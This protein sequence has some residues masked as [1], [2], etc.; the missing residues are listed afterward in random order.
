M[1]ENTA[2]FISPDHFFPNNKSLKNV[3]DK[4]DQ[5]NRSLYLISNKKIISSGIKTQIELPKIILNTAEI[6]HNHKFF[7]EYNKID[8]L[9]KFIY[10]N[11][12]NFAALIIQSYLFPNTAETKLIIDKKI[13]KF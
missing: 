8:N 10:K 2:V 5:N 12:S 13:S 3:Y 11:K 7:Y 1:L 6:E 9:K 4:F